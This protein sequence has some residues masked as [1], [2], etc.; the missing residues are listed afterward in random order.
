MIYLKLNL[1]FFS[2]VDDGCYVYFP[3]KDHFRR[4]W[5]IVRCDFILKISVRG[6][7]YL[8]WVL[9]DR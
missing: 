3:N 2:E 6:F 4:V 7:K 1:C 9:Y 5:L 8:R